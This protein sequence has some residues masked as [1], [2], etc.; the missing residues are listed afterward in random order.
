MALNK[1]YEEKIDR[2]WNSYF[3]PGTTVLKNKLGIVDS[4]ELKEKEAEIS[5]EKLVELYEK[6]IKGN[7]D[8][9]HLKAIHR[10][11]FGDLYEWAGEYRYVNMQKETM[12]TQTIYIDEFLTGEL[13][14]MNQE[15]KSIFDKQRLAVFLATYYTQLMAIHPFREGNGRSCREFLR[16]FVEEK[17]KN[18]S[19]GPLELDWTKFDGTVFLENVSFSLVF[20]S[21]IEMEFMKSLIPS[22]QL[23]Q[24][25][26]SNNLP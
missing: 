19:S 3:F 23:N 16:E 15:I 24:D 1:D 20:R 14:L 6:P 5:F 2:L 8:K 13:E 11:I 18:F 4:D 25:M 9:E 22:D 7:F 12:F 17:T 21:A 10:Y 26:P